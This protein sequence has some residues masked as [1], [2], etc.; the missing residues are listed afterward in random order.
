MIKNALA[1]LAS[2]DGDEMSPTTW[3]KAWVADKVKQE[4]SLA[5]SE[6]KLVG[7]KSRIIESEQKPI[8]W[9]SWRP[10]ST[11]LRLS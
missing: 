3:I 9:T 11:K 1:A 8:L 5:A 7:A 4:K 6:E 10:K 2:T